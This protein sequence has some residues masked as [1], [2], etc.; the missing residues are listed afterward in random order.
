MTKIDY[1]LWT[2]VRGV[3]YRPERGFP[4]NVQSYQERVGMEV[5]RK[6]VISDPWFLADETTF[7]QRFD[8]VV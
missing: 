4:A 8:V 7:A 2:L 5:R 6:P 1:Y 3:I